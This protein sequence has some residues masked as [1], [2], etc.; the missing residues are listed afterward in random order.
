MAMN[1]DEW[2]RRITAFRAQTVI[3]K[4]GVTFIWVLVLLIL[5]L[6]GVLR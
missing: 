6:A 1:Y 5:G 3:W 2:E 4:V